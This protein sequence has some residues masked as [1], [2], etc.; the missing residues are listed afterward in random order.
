[1]DKEVKEMLKK[2]AV[3]QASIV[4]EEF[5]SS[6]FLV[7][8]EWGAK[9]SNKSKASKCVYTIQSLQ[10][11]SIAKSEI[12]VTRGRLYV[13]VQSKGCILLRSFTR[14]LKEIGS[15]PLVTKLIRI[16]VLMF[17]LGSCPTNFHKIIKNPNCNFASHKYKNDYLLGRHASNGSLHRGHEHVSRRRNLVTTSEFCNKLEKVCFDTS[18]G[19]RIFGRNISHRRENTES[20]NKMLKFTDRTRSFDFRINKSDWL[21]DINNPSS[22]ASTMSLSSA[23]ANIIFKGKPFISAKNSSEPPIKDRNTMLDNKSRSLQ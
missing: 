16:S 8:K 11:G 4:K 10:N 14:N 19:N 18:A 2:G 5:L 3:R 20:K 17:W 15:V 13:Q 21:V 7:K 1:M 22:T 12:F 23:A 6:L 9:A